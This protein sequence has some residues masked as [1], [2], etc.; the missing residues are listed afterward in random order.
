ML[1]IDSLALSAVFPP[2]SQYKREVIF[3]VAVPTISTSLEDGQ[4][5]FKGEA[6]GE[7]AIRNGTSVSPYLDGT[8]GKSK[9]S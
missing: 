7:V 3:K 1:L 2:M 9:E 6:S 5:V 4:F 8:K